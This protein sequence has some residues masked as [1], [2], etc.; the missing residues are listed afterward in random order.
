VRPEPSRGTPQV[1]AAVAMESKKLSF[2]RGSHPSIVVCVSSRTHT[3]ACKPPS[4]L[5]QHIPT[6][7]WILDAYTGL[8][9]PTLCQEAHGRWHL[10]GELAKKKVCI[11]SSNSGH[12]FTP[13]RV[14]QE[15]ANRCMARDPASRPTFPDIEDALDQIDTQLRAA[16]HPAP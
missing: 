10:W 7:Q 12:L 8:S 4:R 14:S 9:G 16:A 2:L 1:L 11:I 15:L 5:L 13:N 6:A 3:L